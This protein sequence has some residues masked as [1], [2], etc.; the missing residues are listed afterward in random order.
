[1]PR[2]ETNLRDRWVNTPEERQTIDFSNIDETFVYN[3]IAKHPH[4]K[5]VKKFLY[6]PTKDRA[7]YLWG[8]GDRYFIAPNGV[9]FHIDA[10]FNNLSHWSLEFELAQ[11]DKIPPVVLNMTKFTTPVF[12]ELGWV[13]IMREHAIVLPQCPITK[14]QSYVI[15]EWIKQFGE[16][17]PFYSVVFANGEI[18][19]IEPEDFDNFKTSNYVLG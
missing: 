1:M 4:V 17:Y 8:S 5:K 14:A 9:I 12:E 2:Y 15:E 18:T 3:W 19:Q 11:M 10:T 7:Y 16:T 6:P 13:K